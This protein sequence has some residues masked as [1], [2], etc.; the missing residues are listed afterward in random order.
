M[1]EW[2]GTDLRTRVSER[3]VALA[4]AIDGR[5]VQLRQALELQAPATVAAVP[6]MSPT[7]TGHAAALAAPPLPPAFEEP[8]RRAGPGCGVEA[9]L[10]LAWIDAAASERDPKMSPRDPD[11]DRAEL[12]LHLKALKDECAFIEQVALMAHSTTRISLNLPTVPT[13]LPTLHRAGGAGR[14]GDGT[15]VFLHAQEAAEPRPRLAQDIP[16][17]LPGQGQYLPIHPFYY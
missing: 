6:P 8:E 17:P 7:R 2:V 13:Y 9:A 10:A 1:G 4:K 14:Q 12:K 15:G 16:A 3:H 11:Q 5:L